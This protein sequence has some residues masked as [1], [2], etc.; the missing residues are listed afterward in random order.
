MLRQVGGLAPARLGVRH[1]LLEAVREANEDPHRLPHSFCGA[2]APCRTQHPGASPARKNG[3]RWSGRSGAS[4]SASAPHRPV[5]G[6][7]HAAPRGRWA[8]S[9]SAIAESWPAESLR[10]NLRSLAQIANAARL[11]V[12]CLPVSEG[13]DS[14]PSTCQARKALGAGRAKRC[15]RPR[16]SSLQPYA[17]RRDLDGPALLAPVAPGR[18]LGGW[19][20]RPATWRIDTSA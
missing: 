9:A 14:G 7:S 1:S 11:P 6:A 16:A 19:S 20:Q 13:R 15:S 8:G 10:A 18:R 3:G 2:T 12:P 5:A 4:S 17:E